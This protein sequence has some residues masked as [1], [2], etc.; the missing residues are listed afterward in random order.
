M[1][2]GLQVDFLSLK[3]YLQNNV[4]TYEAGLKSKVFPLNTLA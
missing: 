1:N 4:L 3:K 2:Y